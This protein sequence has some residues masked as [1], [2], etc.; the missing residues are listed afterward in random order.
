[1]LFSN[2]LY[3]KGDPMTALKGNNSCKIYNFRIKV[4]NVQIVYCLSGFRTED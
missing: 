2:E 3:M 1:M 4:G